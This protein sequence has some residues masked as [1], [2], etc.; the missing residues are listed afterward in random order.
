TLG[1]ARHARTRQTVGRQSGGLERSRLRH[2]SRVDHTGRARL[3]KTRFTM[4]DFLTWPA[5]LTTMSTNLIR[6]LAVDDHAIFRQGIA[7]FLADQTDMKLIAEAS[8][9]RE[10][11]QQFR[12]HRPEITLMDLE[13]PEVNG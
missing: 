3:G 11:I 5:E 13:M 8:N 6:I 7:G 10:A 4:V 2:G 9:G 12:A 1:L